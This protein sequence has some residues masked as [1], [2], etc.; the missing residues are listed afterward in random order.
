MDA[1]D[2][3]KINFHSFNL[4]K[5]TAY[6]VLVVYVCNRIKLYHLVH[7]L[8]YNIVSALTLILLD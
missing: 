7:I 8:G 6:N 5:K 1:Q 4:K 2:C 3:Q